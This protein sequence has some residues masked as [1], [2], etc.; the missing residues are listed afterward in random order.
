VEGP[1]YFP[2]GLSFAPRTVD[3]RGGNTGHNYCAQFSQYALLAP[4]FFPLSLVRPHKPMN[5]FEI[6][7]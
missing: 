7:T 1:G 5:R 6:L 4:R 2:D 3:G